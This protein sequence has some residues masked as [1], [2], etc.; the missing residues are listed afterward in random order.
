MKRAARLLTPAKGGGGFRWNPSIPAKNSKDDMLRAMPRIHT[1]E[2]RDNPNENKYIINI[3]LDALHK[4]NNAAMH[5]ANELGLLNETCRIVTEDCNHASAWI[6]L[7][8][9]ADT[10]LRPV[11]RA[12]LQE[13]PQEWQHV[14][15]ADSPAS[16]AMRS[17]TVQICRWS[18]A[19]PRIGLWS[20]LAFKPG[21]SSAIFLPLK[22]G[23]R[24]I[25]ALAIYSEQSDA[26]SEDEV[27]MLVAITDALTCGI[28]ALRSRLTNEET[29][30]ALR[31][32]EFRGRLLSETISLLLTTEDPNKF[33]NE[34]CCNVMEYLDCQAFANFLPNRKADNFVLNVW[35][36]IS[37]EQAQRVRVLE[38]GMTI[39]GRVA[40]EHRCVVVEDIAASNDPR[41]ELIRS[42]G[43]QAYACYPLLVENRLI[44]ILSFGT[45]TRK[46][47]SS[48]DLLLI[49]TVADQVAAAL[50]RIRLVSEL[51][52]SRNTLERRIFD[53]TAELSANEIK[54]RKL[55]QEFQTLLSAISDT[56]VLLSP[57]LEVLWTN[58][59]NAS[60]LKVPATEAAGKKCFQLV[61]NRSTP[62]EVCPV[63]MCMQTAEKEFVVE[64]RDGTVLDKKAFPIKEEGK[65]TSAILIVSDITEKMTMQAEMMQAG[66]MASLGE[67]AAGIAHEINNPMTGIIN[68]GQILVNECSPESMEIDIGRRIVKE[69]EKI[70]R[71]VSNLLSYT[72]DRRK[73]KRPNHLPVILEESISLTQ[74]QIR[75]E[76]IAINIDVPASLPEVNA[77]FQQIQQGFI[78]II[79]NAR[80][81]LNEKY[82]GRHANKRL[83]ISSERVLIDGSPFVRIIFHDRGTGIPAHQLPILT[84]PFFSTKPFRQ[85][86]GLGLNITK[87]IIADHGG[88]LNFES[89]QGEFTKVIIDLPAH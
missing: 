14:I 39:S 33:I 1:L 63:Q 83:D 24:A 46:S 85:G 55:S 34:L 43:L 25:G 36:G 5:S 58:G 54:Y 23:D 65:V 45:R 50:E 21:C 28:T 69:G 84:K 52:E 29:Q 48:Q 86:T 68:Y 32:S 62:C 47:F 57:E 49:K 53:R 82:P 67:L 20:G 35:T 9:D 26:F 64:T 75:K 3:Y 66:H 74:A 10:D 22:S 41:T 11:A 19:K 40:R 79:N 30:K 18:E 44:G 8:N 88:T 78:N 80:F 38:Y 16:T 12:G 56:L 15:A 60:L 81:A 31:E 73:S 61:C 70:S 87:K 17:G 37:E 7:T 77:N 89:I 71:I 59:G 76:G 2:E 42:Y 4:I 27:G 6:G 72:R 51:K 13:G